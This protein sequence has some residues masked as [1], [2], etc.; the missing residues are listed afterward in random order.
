MPCAIPGCCHEMQAL[1]ITS[2]LAEHPK[3]GSQ[4]SRSC[5]LHSPQTAASLLCICLIGNLLE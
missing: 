2:A 4:L 1:S 5:N 3:E